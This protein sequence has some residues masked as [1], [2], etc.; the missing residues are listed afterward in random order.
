MNSLENI[1]NIFQATQP[2]SRTD[3]VL[4]EI[5]STLKEMTCGCGSFM[6]CF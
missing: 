6:D 1:A 5:K 4:K 2:Q 3:T